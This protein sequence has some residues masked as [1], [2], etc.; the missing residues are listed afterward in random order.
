MNGPCWSGGAGGDVGVPGD[1][2][3]VVDGMQRIIDVE[4]Q[5]VDPGGQ[6]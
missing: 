1:G 2:E 6:I 5:R 4:D 3:A